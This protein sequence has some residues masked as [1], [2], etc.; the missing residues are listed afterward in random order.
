MPGLLN[1]AQLAVEVLLQRLNQEVV[2]ARLV[3]TPH[4]R[5]SLVQ[6]GGER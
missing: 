4:G 3:A 6:E 5:N 2:G 1:P